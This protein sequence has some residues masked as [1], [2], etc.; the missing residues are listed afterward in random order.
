MKLL[1]DENVDFSVI[2]R[3]RGSGHEVISIAEESPGL[4]DQN[5][6]AR[7]IAEGKLLITGDKDFGELVYRHGQHHSGVLLMRLSGV[8]DHDKGTLVCQAMDQYG[9]QLSGAFSVLEPTELRI[10]RPPEATES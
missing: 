8:P 2:S 6:L 10:R 9:D 7:A 4:S 5:V 1:A 3:L